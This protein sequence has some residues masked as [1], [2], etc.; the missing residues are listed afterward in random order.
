MRPDRFP[1]V[2]D[3]MLAE[4]IRQLLPLAERAS[5]EINERWA[6]RAVQRAEMALTMWVRQERGRA[7]LLDGALPPHA[8]FLTRQ[9]IPNIPT[10]DKPCRLN[11]CVLSEQ[12]ERNSPEVLNDIL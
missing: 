11:V 12:A 2:N 3:V 8:R 4:A 10:P 9:R 7:K 5:R 6:D 1:E